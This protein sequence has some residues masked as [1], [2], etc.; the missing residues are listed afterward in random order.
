MNAEGKN[1]TFYAKINVPINESL[2]C[3]VIS[4]MALMFINERT[5]ALELY[6]LDSNSNPDIA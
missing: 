3:T 5:W 2:A 6:Q 4:M 1:I